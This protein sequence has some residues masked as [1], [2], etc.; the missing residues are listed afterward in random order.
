MKHERSLN[1]LYLNAA[2]QKSLLHYAANASLANHPGFG[3]FI[4]DSLEQLSNIVEEDDP[5]SQLM[6]AECLRD[7]AQAMINRLEAGEAV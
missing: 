1:P 4:A 5:D 7:A 2:Q 6:A 3:N